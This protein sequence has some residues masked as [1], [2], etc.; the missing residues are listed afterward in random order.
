MNRI[1]NRM[2]TQLFFAFIL[3]FILSILSIL[4]GF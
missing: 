4:S 3:C 2:K 1:E